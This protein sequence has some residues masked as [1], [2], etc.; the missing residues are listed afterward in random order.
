M[1]KSDITY[2][3]GSVFVS[4]T[5]FFYSLIVFFKIP[6]VRYYPTEHRWTTEK[7]AGAVSQGWYG[8][9][10]YA[11]IAA[12]IASFI[13]FFLLKTTSSGQD[14]ELKTAMSKLIGIITVL[15]IIASMGYILYHE[16]AKWGV[17]EKFGI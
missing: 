17:F 8:L 7:I 1:R 16:Y 4:L 14:K 15:V 2:V 12:A 9:Q 13:V 10:T 6:V 5:A 11:F 3:T